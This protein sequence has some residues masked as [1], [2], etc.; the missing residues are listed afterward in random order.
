MRDGLINLGK[1][2]WQYAD[3][4]LGSALI[5]G[6]TTYMITRGSSEQELTDTKIEL[7]QVESKLKIKE[8]E[9]SHLTKE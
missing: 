6:T 4:H 3:S 1:I 7:D 5:A 9:V 8:S 2:I